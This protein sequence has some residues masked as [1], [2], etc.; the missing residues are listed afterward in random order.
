MIP[1][2]NFGE[3]GAHSL[4]EIIASENAEKLSKGQVREGLE[5]HIKEFVLYPEVTWKPLKA[6]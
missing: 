6:F 2:K 4:R 3:V 1:K 5:G